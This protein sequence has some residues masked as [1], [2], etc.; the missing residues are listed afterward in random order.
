M[1]ACAEEDAQGRRV[2]ER[3]LAKIDHDPLARIQEGGELA[4]EPLGG[5]RVVLADEGD[6]GSRGVPPS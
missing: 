5:V 1:Q 4:L 3:G 2:D 6:H